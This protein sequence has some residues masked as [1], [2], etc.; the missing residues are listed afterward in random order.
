MIAVTGANGML[1]RHIIKL[2]EL[3]GIDSKAIDR[4]DWDLSNWLSLEELDSLFFDCVAVFHV[5]AQVPRQNLD[6]SNN[7]V[8][9]LFDA[10]VRSCLNLAHW[11]CL[12]HV[13]LLF[14]SGSTVY[15][16]PHASQI[17]ENAPKVING[18][19]GFYGYTKKLAEDIFSHYVMQGLKLIVLR[20]TS[21]YG[22]GLPGDKLVSNFLLRA[23]NGELI[24][25]NQV[26]SKVN[27]IHAMDVASGALKAFSS[28]AWG[29]YNL[30][31]QLY[32][33]KQ[34]AETA[35][36][37]ACNGSLELVMD[38]GSEPYVRFD[39]N[40]QLAFQS[41]NFS[42]KIELREGMELMLNQSEVNL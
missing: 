18:F 4:K 6:E 22:F 42:T 1:G 40:D 10:N 3:N 13:P 8:R 24:T 29:T 11:A 38:E 2:F 25:V 32:S 21:I 26:N 7:D 20:P 5:G 27:L 36:S 31:G 14:I 30:S 19:G 15:E 34:I 37:V 17:N 9:V 16:D 12:R 41:F 39:L 28:Q 35:I 23:K 33:I